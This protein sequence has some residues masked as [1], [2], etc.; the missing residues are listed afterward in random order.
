MMA[1]DGDGWLVVV[2]GSVTLDQYF[3]FVNPYPPG[4]QTGSNNFEH[5]SSSKVI[6]KDISLGIAK[7]K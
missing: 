6:L 5:S 3:L 1:G 2:E 4:A 7:P